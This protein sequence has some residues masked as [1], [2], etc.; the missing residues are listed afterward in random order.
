[1]EAQLQDAVHYWLCTVRADGRPHAVPKWAVWV[2]GKIYFDGSP[3][4]RHARNLA[5]N[6]AVVI[7]LESGEQAVIVEGLARAIDK[8]A[9]EL[10]GMVAA[11]YRRKYAGLG[12]APKQTQWD[13][14][15]LFE[16]GPR[17]V[18]AWTKFTED[19]TKFILSA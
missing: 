3:E 14:G 16:I 1:V 2:E 10:A 18:L 6:P 5:L 7:H 17:V 19:P 15:G 11:A 12:Y 8:P 4:T 9:V 13:A